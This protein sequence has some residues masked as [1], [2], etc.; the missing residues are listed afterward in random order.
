MESKMVQADDVNLQYFE[1]GRG[2]ETVVLVH[3]FA[4]NAAIWRYTIERLA[5]AGSFR[6]IALNNRGA[7][8]SDRSEFESAYSVESFAGDLYNA[9][10]ALGLSGFTLVGH[11]MGGATVT[12]FALEDQ[13]LL[14]ALVLLNSTPLKGRT[15]APNWEGELR[16]SFAAGGQ[17][18]G[19]M[20]FN[21][22]HV[23]QDF[24]D[25]VI[26]VIRRNPIERAIGGR[27]SMFALRLRERL[28]EIRVPT[29]VVGGDR[30]TTVGIDNI[31]A[32]YLALPEETRHL[33][34]FHGIGHSPN[35]E[36]PSLFAGLLSR[37]IAKVNAGAAAGI[38][39]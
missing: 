37:F 29:L 24:I 34:I 4:S 21:A 32:E 15:P 26:S 8:D 13:G 10:S 6:V 1:E 11:S 18:R 23:S 12:R 33:H 17:T 38:A 25:E 16:E 9:V 2:P 7:G 35:V 39:E 30:D 19:D 28:G 27:R 31:V 22:P 36:A 3:G 14:K 20:G 5:G